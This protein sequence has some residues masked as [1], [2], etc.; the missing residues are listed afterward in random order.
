MKTSYL[1]QGFDQISINA[2]RGLGTLARGLPNVFRGVGVVGGTAAYVGREAVRGYGFLTRQHYAW[3]TPR[4]GEGIGTHGVEAFLKRGPI[5]HLGQG[6]YNLGWSAKLLPFDIA[7][8][9]AL[10]LSDTD[11]NKML[12]FQEGGFA[13]NLVSNFAMGPGAIVGQAIGAAIGS[14]LPIPGATAIGLVGGALAGNFV[15]D[16]L[17]APYD[18]AQ[19]RR[20]NRIKAFQDSPR[21]Y[22]MRARSMEMISNSH[23]AG[24]SVLGKEAL[25]WHL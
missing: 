22:T 19:T 8:S 14:V 9:S 2:A 23:V 24:R 21:A 7:L 16:L 5:G 6:V 4:I 20:A 1:Q 15:G 18:I 10:A 13:R 12:S 11:T 17:F 25:A 3:A